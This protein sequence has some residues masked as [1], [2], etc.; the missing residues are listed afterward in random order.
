MRMRREFLA[1]VV[2]LSLPLVFTGLI[3]FLTS[4]TSSL[5]V[6][7]LG[8]EATAAIYTGT[9]ILTALTMLVGG[10]EGGILVSVP[11]KLGEKDGRRACGA[12]A[13]GV[14]AV[15]LLGAVSTALILPFSGKIASLILRG[16]DSMR[17]AE[18]LRTL[19][20]SFLPTAVSLALGAVAKAT[21]STRYP[22]I[23][24]LVAFGVNLALCYVLIFGKGG[25]PPMGE[26]G[27]AV[28]IAV[29]RG[30][31]ALTLL[32]LLLIKHRGRGIFRTVKVALG[33]IGRGVAKDFLL[34]VLPLLLGQTVWIINTLFS[35]SL[36]GKV[37]TG[38]DFAG[39][40]IANTL[41][42]VSYIIPSA[43]AVG[44]GIIISRGEGER[45]EEDKSNTANAKKAKIRVAEILFICIG[46][47]TAIALLLSRSAF[48]S[49][50]NVS[51]NARA[52]A[53]ALITVV[54]VTAGTNVYGNSLLLG[55]IRASGDVTFPPKLDA[56][57]VLLVIIP[58]SLIAARLGA[59]LPLI[60]L[61][62][63][64]DH[65][66]KIIPTRMRI[67]TFGASI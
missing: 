19:T 30:A 43:L 55:I 53:S 15:T 67:S 60:F 54:A 29:S 23:A 18:Y 42:T 40:A 46:A 51:E 61:I 44:L 13:I 3:N 20:A 27:A 5:L 41:N 21:G 35:A 64:C 17:A 65:I 34:C 36:I 63:R 47:G 56:F 2:K 59:P 26:R 28:A 7:R 11:K 48:I 57:F 66:L 33:G 62:T 1:D 45:E 49:L 8:D 10:I 12:A 14:I 16:T 31:E 24:S 22:L 25:I 52:T 38:A 4:L 58:A 32:L 9:L 6:G 39:L 37:G 50:Y